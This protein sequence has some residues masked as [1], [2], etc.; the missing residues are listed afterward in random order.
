MNSKRYDIVI[1][2]IGGGALILAYSLASKGYNVAVFEKGAR[3]LFYHRGEIVQ[4]A[5]IEILA[6]L[7]LLPDLMKEDIHRFHE[8]CFYKTT[9][10]HLCTSK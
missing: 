9:G 5:S 2:G 4:P 6:R 7:N 3:P 10:Q 8:V 1:I